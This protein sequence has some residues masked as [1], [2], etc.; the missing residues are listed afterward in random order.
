ML[1][2]QFLDGNIPTVAI[3]AVIHK[4]GC[5]ILNGILEPDTV[6]AAGFKIEIYRACIVEI[7]SL[8]VRPGT[9]FYFGNINQIRM[10]RHV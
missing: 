2:Y 5:C 1:P 6:S 7:I 3:I 10:L 9:C 4:T 8:R